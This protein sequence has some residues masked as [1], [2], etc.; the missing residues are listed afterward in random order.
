MDNLS[1][2]L[3][4]QAGGAVQQLVSAFEQ[5]NHQQVPDAQVQ[6]TYGQTAAQLPQDQYL[7]AA[8]EAFTRLTPQQR[9]Q[10]AQEL[11]TQAQQQGVSLPMPSQSTST[12]DASGLAN[13]V[14]AVHG[15]QPNL[16]QQMFAP[17]GTFSSPVAKAALLG[18]TAMAAQRMMGRR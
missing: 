9:Q 15:Q 5:G 3:G 6:Q 18:I 7:E 14:T 8:R 12:A 16:L 17:G 4:G 11:Q 1:N 10:F 13:A 2:I